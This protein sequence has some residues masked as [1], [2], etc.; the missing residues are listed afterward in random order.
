MQGER[1]SGKLRAYLYNNGTY[2]V[3]HQFRLFQ[4]KSMTQYSKRM[5]IVHWLSLALIIAAWF[6]GESLDEARHEGGATIA[7]YVAHALVG[8]VVLLLTVARLTFRRKD[9]V[10]APMGNA[11]IDKVATGMHSALYFV[12]ILLSVSGVL[13]I[14]ASDVGKAI[15]T[16][17]AALLPAKFQGVFAHEI[18]E[19][20]V[21]AL[22]VLVVVHALGALKHQFVM[23]DGLMNRMWLGK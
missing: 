2:G 11:L 5:V 16:G 21:T 19:L 20:L 1:V 13:I 7:G 15:L 14:A 8:G 10:P 6:L 18:H 23:K 17:D 3:I 22:I 9:G 12:L 4:E